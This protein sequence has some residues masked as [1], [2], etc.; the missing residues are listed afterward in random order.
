VNSMISSWI[1]NVIDSKSRRSIACA[2]ATHA[3]WSTLKKRYGVA[4]VSKIHQLKA[5]I[6]DCKHGG[7]DIIEFCSKLSN[8]WSAL[9]NHVKVPHCVCTKCDCK[10]EVR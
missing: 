3:M 2:E 5:N 6:V 10:E 4:N 9:E 7:L 8:L 1:I